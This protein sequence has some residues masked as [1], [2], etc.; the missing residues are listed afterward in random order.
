MKSHPSQPRTLSEHLSNSA[1]AP[2]P[3]PRAKMEVGTTHKIK[4]ALASVS[5]VEAD[6]RPPPGALAGQR[7]E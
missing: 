7:L 3:G 2:E 5:L 6:P 1:L 4:R